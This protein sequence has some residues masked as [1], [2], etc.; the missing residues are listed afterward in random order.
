MAH[1]HRSWGPKT[2]SRSSGQLFVTSQLTRQMFVLPQFF[3]G[4]IRHERIYCLRWRL[5]NLLEGLKVQPFV[6]PE[7]MVLVQLKHRRSPHLCFGY[8]SPRRRNFCFI[9]RLQTPL[10]KPSSIEAG[11]PALSVS[12]H[13]R[14]FHL[15][16]PHSQIQEER[17]EA[18]EG[19]RTLGADRAFFSHSERAMFNRRHRGNAL[20]PGG[21][22]LG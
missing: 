13:L 11:R 1:F 16:S 6:L 7:C 4:Y 14:M 3:S 8:H 21:R 17:C 15:L 2:V 18:S 22:I 10:W 5:R 20:T 19:K 9:H 12:F